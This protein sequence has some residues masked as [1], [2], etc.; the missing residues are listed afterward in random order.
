MSSTSQDLH[1]DAAL[2]EVALGYRPEGF[3]ADMIMPVVD[4]GK[5]SDLYTI[6]SREDRLRIHDTKRAPGTE[7]KRI[8]ESVSSETYYANNYALQASVKLEDFKNADPIYLDNLNTGKV[9]LVMDGL[10]LDWEVRA[11]NQVTS[12]SNVGSYSAV[13]SQWN[14]GNLGSDPIGD[15]NTIMDNVQYS[16]GKR[17]NRLTFGLKAWQVFRRHSDVRNI[18]FGSNNGGG[19]A[20]AAQVADLFEVEDIQVGGAFQNTAGEGLTENLSAIW[21]DHIL[22][23][24]T[25]ASASKERPSFGYVFRW[26]QPGLPNM[27][28]ERHPYDSKKK[29]Q[30][31]E[32]GYY[33]DEKIT[34][35]EYGFLLTNVT[36]ST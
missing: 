35:A 31:I 11:A 34:G 9:E 28:V 25:P 14:D 29:S 8:E 12:G 15:I 23:H 4:V 30:E 5:Q 10:M 26:N 7:A 18:I 36:S 27:Q 17:P 32:V 21:D 3:I 6:W 2:S 24:Y 22:A 20:S 19:F 33:Q 16:T 13:A 1:I